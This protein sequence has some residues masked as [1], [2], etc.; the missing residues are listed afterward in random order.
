MSKTAADVSNDIISTLSTTCPGLS[1]QIGTVERKIIDAVAEAISEA[2]VDTYLL[3]S[4]LDINTKTGLEL[5]Q[6]VGIFGFGRMQGK[7]ANGVVTVTLSVAS[8]SDQP[9]ALGTQF[10]TNTNAVG[11]STPLYFASSQAAII[12]AGTYTTDIPVSCTTVG[13]AGNVGPDSVNFVG[14]LLGSSAVTNLQAMTGG[15]DP[16]SDAALRQRFKD[17]LMRNAAG[18]SDF[19]EAICIQN[20]TVSKVRVFGPTTLETLQIVAPADSVTLPE[21]NNLKFA[22]PDSESV[23]T[24][25]GQ[26]DEAFYFS[27]VDYTWDNT[28][29]E[30]V[31]LTD[32]AIVTGAILDIE[33]EYTTQA[34][35]ND[36]NNSITN[37]VDIFVDG[38]DPFQ[39]T[40]RATLRDADKL[41]N[42]GSADAVPLHISNFK[43]VGG[44][45]TPTNNNHFTRL[46]M[47]PIGTLPQSMVIAGNTYVRNTDYWQL[48]PS[49]PSSGVIPNQQQLLKGSAYEWSGIEWASSG[50]TPTTE[51]TL[52]YVYNR[53]IR[54]LQSVI[55]TAKQV[56]TDVMVHQ[57]DFQY[58]LPTIYIEYDRN[59]SMDATNTAIQGRLQVYFAGLGYGGTV[60]ITGMLLSVQQVIGVVSCQLA[61]SGDSPT[62]PSYGIAIYDEASDPSPIGSPETSDF[63]INDNQLAQALPAML[64]RKPL[65]S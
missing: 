48:E 46:S 31:R 15:T 13:V 27:G 61:L 34:S 18:T 39:V 53:A 10:F 37:K 28:D 9:V 43:R 33:Y 7:Q 4:L 42:S 14:T 1:C 20:V 5:E 59:Y 6:F 11:G 60:T 26:A 51:M 2:Y 30:F 21:G 19:Y 50:P 23:F 58:M 38:Y 36:P 29:N 41:T 64:I 54:T 3:G 63:P 16:E 17:T 32:G 40:E 12:T 45:G 47:T 44:T 35:R 25:L 52:T 8:E 57:A 22:W 55:K 65:P 62:P 56:T 24:D 49:M